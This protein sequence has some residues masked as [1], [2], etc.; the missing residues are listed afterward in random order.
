MER[1]FSGTASEIKQ[2][3]APLE[4]SMQAPPHRVPL[5]AADRGAGP[6]L[7]ISRC[8]RV[9]GSADCVRIDIGNVESTRLGRTLRQVRGEGLSRN[10][11]LADH[12][13]LFRR[14][15]P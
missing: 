2:C 9:K 10:Q 14:S 5:Q 4:E 13:P 3:L 12:E 15:E 1:I 8:E 6:Q 11:R 7:V